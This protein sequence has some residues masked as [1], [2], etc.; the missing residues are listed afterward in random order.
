[1]SQSEII[2][3]VENVDPVALFGENNIKLNLIRKSF[4]DIT[5]TSRGSLIKILGKKK[6][7]QTVK[8]KLN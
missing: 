8:E 5:I 6:E 1:M 7:T 2:L 3:T 4:P